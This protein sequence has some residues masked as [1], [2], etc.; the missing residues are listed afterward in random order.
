VWIWVGYGVQWFLRLLIGVIGAS[1]VVGTLM[2]VWKSHTAPPRP[3]EVVVDTESRTLALPDTPPI[4]TP[5]LS[6]TL[7]KLIPPNQGL[8]LHTVLLELG[9]GT[10]VDL[11][12]D[13]SVS[14]AE[15]IRLPILVAVLQDTEANKLRWDQQL[16]R[17]SDAK[18]SVARAVLEM[19][20]RADNTA[21]NLLVSRLGG[22]T[23]LNQ[24]WQ[25]WGL[26]QTRLIS[27]LPD[28]EGTNTTSARDL[29]QLLGMVERGK[30]L[31]L[32]TRDRF[33]DLLARTEDNDLL[34]QG[35]G[36]EARIWHQS[37]TI[38]TLVGDAGIIDLPNGKRYLIAVMIRRTNGN[39]AANEIIRTASANIHDYLSRARRE[40]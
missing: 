20:R 12:G 22:A 5:E 31:K 2:A 4:P 38:D 1:V 40:P 19:T 32:R 33:F 26:K 9:A 35:I 11:R 25:E 14:A 7:E 17:G 27:P 36:T 28:R 13:V 18:I 21:T 23:A 39:T 34:P 29:V 8:S 6:A 15:M 30:L 24:R 10:A 3:A 37:G 16:E